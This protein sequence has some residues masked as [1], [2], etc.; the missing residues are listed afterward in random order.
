MR[1]KQKRQ[2]CARQ[3]KLRLKQSVKKPNAKKPR[4]L[5]SETE[6]LQGA[7]SKKVISKDSSRRL[8][9]GKRKMLR[10]YRLRQRK[11]RAELRT[12]DTHAV[13]LMIRTDLLMKQLRYLS[14][15]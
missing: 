9:S 8:S 7:R 13:V 6:I 2:N 11:S 3:K 4:V 15:L 5:L 1:R 10:L 12:G 14:L